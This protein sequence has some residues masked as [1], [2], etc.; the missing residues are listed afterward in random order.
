MNS[1]TFWLL[2]VLLLT[3]PFQLATAQQP[4]KIYRI[5]LLSSGAPSSS[6]TRLR[7]FRQGLQDL[8]YLEGK[9]LVIEQRYLKGNVKLTRSLVAELVQIK[10]DV[11]VS[12]VYAAIIVGTRSSR[13]ALS[14]S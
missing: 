13:P 11:I 9:N 4:K 1:K 6:P 3:S 7:A 2:A 12:S 8:G 5:G 10:V 14:C